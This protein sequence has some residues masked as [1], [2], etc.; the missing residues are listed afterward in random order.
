MSDV[1]Q[2]LQVHSIH[3]K[4]CIMGIR[5]LSATPYPSSNNA[6]SATNHDGQGS[7]YNYSYGNWGSNSINYV[8][9]H[10][11]SIR[12]VRNEKSERIKKLPKVNERTAP[13]GLSAAP[14]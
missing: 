13:P 4:I 3:K 1:T 8:R 7:R 12:I 10:F 2:K 6:G 11:L 9:P 14:S 5:A